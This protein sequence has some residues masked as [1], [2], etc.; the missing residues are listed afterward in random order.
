[1]ALLASL[2]K[3]EA[4]PTAAVSEAFRHLLDGLEEGLEAKE[5]VAGQQLVQ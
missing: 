5:S 2:S 3:A 4:L 1:M